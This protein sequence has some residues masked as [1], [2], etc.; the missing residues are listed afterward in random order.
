MPEDIQSL[1]VSSTIKA[2]P[3]FTEDYTLHRTVFIFW[4]V[5]GSVGG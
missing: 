5:G 3:D 4:S 2:E 1:S